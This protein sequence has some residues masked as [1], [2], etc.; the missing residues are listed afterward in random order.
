MDLLPSELKAIEHINSE[1][2]VNLTPEEYNLLITSQV[3]NKTLLE[4]KQSLRIPKYFSPLLWFEV[5]AIDA[6]AGVLL[7]TD[8]LVEAKGIGKIL[9]VV[10]GVV[11]LITGQPWLLAIASLGFKLFGSKKES[12]IEEQESGR[13]G[14][15]TG[16][17]SVASLLPLNEPL[18]LFF[19]DRSADPTGG[20]RSSG[21]LIHSR[22][23]TFNGTQTLYQL[24]SHGWGEIGEIDQSALLVNEQP[25]DNFLVGEINTEYRLGTI[26]QSPILGF[27]VYS[28]CVSLQANNSLGIDFKGEPEDVIT[29]SNVID[30]RGDDFDKFD[31]SDI[32]FADNQ[33]FRIINKDSEGTYITAD[34]PLTLA[35]NSQIFSLYKTTY[36][37]S[38]KVNEIHVN[39]TLSLWAVD[40]DNNDIKHA[41]LFDVYLTNITTG[42]K[43]VVQRLYTSNNGK[44][45]IRRYFKLKNLSYHKYRIE[46]EPLTIDDGVR[47]A[48]KM[49]DVGQIRNINSGVFFDSQEVIVEVEQKPNHVQDIPSTN[50]HIGY[51]DTK[52]QVSS[53][54]GAPCQITTINEIVY[55]TQHGYN[56]VSG[57][58]GQVITSVIANSSNR[59]GS[60]PRFS[61]LITKGRSMRAIIKA[62]IA[63]VGSTDGQLV[64]ATADFNTEV[65]VSFSIVRNLSRKIE[66]VVTG[67]VNA[68]T[69][70]SNNLGWRFGDRYLVYEVS[71]KPYLSDI[72]A[73]L[74]TDTNGGVGHEHDTDHALD[75]IY[76]A[77]ARAF[78]KLNNFFWHGAV[79]KTSSWASWATA[80]AVSSMLHVPQINGRI[81][82]LPEE[83]ITPT[84][85]FNDSNIYSIEES[86][87]QKQLL[88]SLLVTYK[89]GSD[90]RFPQ[91]SVLIQTVEVTNGLVPLVEESIEFKWV[92]NVT[93]ATTVGAF[94][95]KSRRLQWQSIIDLEVGLQGETVA[96]GDLV[97][98]QH[99]VLQIESEANGFALESVRT[100]TTEVVRMTGLINEGV[101]A[102]NY[103][104][105]VMHLESQ[106]LEWGLNC[107]SFI[108]INGITR[109]TIQGVTEPIVTSTDERIGDY[110]MITLGEAITYRVASVNSNEENGRVQISAII[111]NESMYNMDGLVVE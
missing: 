83:N 15:T 60:N 74:L 102:G 52:K 54:N 94:Y 68:N 48:V 44:T 14:N 29:N 110:I 20:I 6:M 104:A 21:V 97:L 12:D 58:P 88:N 67:V 24:Y 45:Q 47:T 62:G 5:V 17:D 18:K 33:E 27:N 28:Q 90:T 64:D 81:G 79:D 76:F 89:D 2:G 85:M 37:T 109:V 13:A 11:G 69:I 111:W 42:V 108:D 105:A 53:N 63:G 65:V 10:I 22:V 82:C 56:N 41:I 8:V 77:R 93:H 36:E 26:P 84:A 66:S 78:C 50:Q 38:K 23:E 72:I 9:S 80:E 31:P 71:T 96:P 100:G 106:F 98:I 7:L 32:F 43:N 87:D 19:T 30:V 61:W 91:E 46:L 34:R 57:Y 3:Y 99:S 103:T 73:H 35:S 70:I 86:P 40:E 59:I 101:T 39:M 92:T 55:P 107:S 51:P 16:F 49:G 4:A 25:I 75:Y 95:L 1:H